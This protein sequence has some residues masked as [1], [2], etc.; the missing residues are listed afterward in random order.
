MLTDRI[1]TL[2]LVFLFVRE[3][4]PTSLYRRLFTGYMIFQIVIDLCSH[5]L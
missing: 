3:A 1:S 4:E 2:I 5:W